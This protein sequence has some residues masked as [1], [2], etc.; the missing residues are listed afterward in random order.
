VLDALTSV[1]LGLTGPNRRSARVNARGV[2]GGLGLPGGAKPWLASI[3]SPPARAKAV[4]RAAL[5]NVRLTMRRLSRRVRRRWFIVRLH[6]A[7]WLAR[8]RV[9]VDIHPSADLP[10]RVTFEVR[11]RCR[12]SVLLGR[13]VEIQP[14]LRLRLQGTLEVGP[15]S[16]IRHNVTI[17]VKGHLRL[18]GRNV[19]S[20]TCSIHAD[21]DTVLEWGACIAERVSIVDSD[22]GNDGSAVFTL[23]HPVRVAPI[24]IGAAAF[25]ATQSVVT[26]GATIGPCAVVGANSVV[27]RDVPAGVVAVG[28]PAA[29]IRTLPAWWLGSGDAARR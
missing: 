11:P 28:A 21:G 17:N 14:G 13:D 24:R 26:A 22:H 27:T 9:H 15:R 23:D 16:Q 20:H 8:S 10:R 4:V 12:P 25:V 3:A 29:P 5:P 18:A 6:L 1:V 2:L 19:I 7:T